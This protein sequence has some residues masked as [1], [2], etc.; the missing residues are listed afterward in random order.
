MRKS[1]GFTLLTS[2]LLGLVTSSLSPAAETT[3][4]AEPPPAALKALTVFPAEIHLDGPRDEQSV[5]GFVLAAYTPTAGSWDLSGQAK[6]SSSSAFAAVAIIEGSIVRPT[7]DG[8][9]TLTVQ[10]GGQSATVTV[11]VKRDED[12]AVPGQLRRTKSCRAS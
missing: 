6:Y 5:S 12:D 3:L 11:K 1:R 9:A 4:R 10:A 2:G 8:Q 7:G